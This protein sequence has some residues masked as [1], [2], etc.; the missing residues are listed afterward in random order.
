MARSTFLIEEFRLTF[1]APRGVSEAESAA[2]RRAL[3]FRRFHARLHR[4]ARSLIHQYRSL[5][6]LRTTFSR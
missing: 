1:L 3:D 5:R 6:H 2:F 4:A